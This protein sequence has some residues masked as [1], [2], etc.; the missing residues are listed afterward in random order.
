MGFA[1]RSDC[2]PSCWVRWRC[3]A[4]PWFPLFLLFC[5]F[6]KSGSVL[7]YRSNC[8]SARRRHRHGLGS[9]TSQLKGGWILGARDDY[10]RPDLRDISHERGGGKRLIHP[11]ALAFGSGMEHGGDPAAWEGVLHIISTQA[12]GSWDLKWRWLGVGQL[13][14]NTEEYSADLLYHSASKHLHPLFDQ[15]K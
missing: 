3:L 13:L 15:L 2:N 11:L 6:P 1:V 5:C 10:K 7:L 12:D 14:C 8:S 9:S 4:H